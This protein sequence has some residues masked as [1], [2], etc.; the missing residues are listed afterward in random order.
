MCL[1][2]MATAAKTSVPK[3]D[4]QSVPVTPVGTSHMHHHESSSK[5]SKPED[6]VGLKIEV[7]WKDDEQGDTWE[8]ATIVEYKAFDK[9]HLLRYADGDQDWFNLTDI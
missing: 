6:L 3:L 1:L 9:A 7:L 5:N 2:I 4:V 8:K